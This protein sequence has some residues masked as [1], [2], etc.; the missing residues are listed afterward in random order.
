MKLRLKS[1][2]PMAILGLLLGCGGNGSSPKPATG[3]TG[4]GGTP[5]AA[6]ARG[7]DPTNGPGTPVFTADGAE[8]PWQYRG[9]IADRV[10][11]SDTVHHS[12]LDFGG[13]SYLTYHNGAL[14]TGSGYRRS[15]CVDRMNCNDDGT[16]KKIVQTK[17]KDGRSHGG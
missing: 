12:F 10:T 4:A 9:V 1:V 11:N 14:P 5:D 8:G 13:A 3:G 16:I 15:T 17:N 6:A 7:P 2:L